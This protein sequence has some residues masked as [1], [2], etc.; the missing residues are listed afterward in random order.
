MALGAAGAAGDASS[1]A[2]AA[3]GLLRMG[4]RAEAGRLSN[5]MA[6]A[7]GHTHELH[8]QTHPEHARVDSFCGETRSARSETGNPVPEFLS[9]Y[10]SLLPKLCS[11]IGKPPC[12]HGTKTDENRTKTGRK[13]GLADLWETHIFPHKN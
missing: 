12:E 11:H 1:G 10:N 7:T 6:T 9:H 3:A 4:A 5:G 2:G 8:T 13:P